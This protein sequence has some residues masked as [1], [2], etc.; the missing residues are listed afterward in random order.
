[1]LNIC[2]LYQPFSTLPT[3]ELS[4]FLFRFGFDIGKE[5]R[6]E[7]FFLPLPTIVAKYTTTMQAL[8]L[9]RFHPTRVVV[10]STTRKIP[11][12]ATETSL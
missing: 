5:N 2:S 8:P 6:T 10:Y 4:L 11:Y 3:A 1:M 12:F 7:F 9:F